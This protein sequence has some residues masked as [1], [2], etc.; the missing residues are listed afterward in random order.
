MNSR[1]LNGK[2]P[3]AVV[4]GLDCITGLQ[5]AR[6]LNGHQ[7]PVVG[8]T[9]NP[10]HACC[11]T[12]AC[13]EI[14]AA[15]IGSEEF[16]ATLQDL[17]RR[18]MQRAVLIPCTD[19]SVLTI[20]RHRDTLKEWYHIALPDPDVV[21]MLIDKA[22]F[23]AFAQSIGL[24]VP[25]SV[26][27]RNRTEAEHAAQALTFPC[28]L[29]PRTKTAAW[30]TH[31][32]AKAYQVANAQE[33]LTLYDRCARWADA[34]ILQE[35]VVGGEANLYSCNC[36]FDA[37]SNPLVTFIAR[38][39]RQWPPGTGT[40]CLGEECRNDIVEQE[41]IQLFRNVDY[42]G[43]GYVEMKRDERTGQHLVIEP[44]VGRPT[45][46]SAIAEAAGVDLLY[47]MYCDCV[48]WPLP[49]NRVQKY[50]GVKW[51]YWRRDLQSAFHYWRRGD[52]TLRAWWKSWRGRK[53]Y[54]VYSRTDPGPFWSDL[55][56]SRRQ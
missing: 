46:R 31:S 11:R 33:F 3:Y 16:V 32:K 54:A 7:I 39:L 13:E 17:G 37:N 19:M 24:P 55:R 38:K 21:E 47:T 20:S 8:L 41:T 53:G 51:I 18:L 52:L 15:D 23:Y 40:S 26:V 49:E 28:V 6:I 50:E 2:K 22:K 44:N 12:R 34:L 14:I 9:G 29:K 35:W 30:E 5:T 42:R 48:G 36:Y 4:V 56:R 43:L 1:C 45:G 25:K 27:L 10:D